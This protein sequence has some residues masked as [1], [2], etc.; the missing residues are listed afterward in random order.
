MLDDPR[1]DR[2]RLY[3]K[4]AASCRSSA[5]RRCTEGEEL[6]KRRPRS[7]TTSCAPRWSQQMQSVRLNNGR[8]EQLVE[9]LYDLN[10]RLRRG[11]RASCCAWPRRRGVKRQDFLDHHIGHELRP[12]WIERARASCPARAGP[13]FIGKIRRPRSQESARRDRARS[14]TRRG[15]PIGEF[16]RIVADG[17]AAASA[18]RAGPRRRWSRP[19]CASSSR[20]PR[21]TPTAA[22]NSST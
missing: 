14:P 19:I 16:R 13:R 2:R 1:A 12:D 6:P 18:R 7:A 4:P 11:S 5:S 9:Q 10:R 20:S 17:A 8:I 15:L 3:K 22:C 21:N